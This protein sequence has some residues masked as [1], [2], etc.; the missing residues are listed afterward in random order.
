MINYWDFHGKNWCKILEARIGGVERRREKEKQESIRN[1]FSG[2]PNYCG[3][4]WGWAVT[5]C[6]SFEVTSRHASIIGAI[7]LT[8]M[9]QKKR[10]ITLFAM[11]FRLV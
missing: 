7:P 8:R 1:Q 10:Q 6:Y 9:A 5:K 3:C 2:R 11:Y 4:G